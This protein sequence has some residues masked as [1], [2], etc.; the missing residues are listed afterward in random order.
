MHKIWFFWKCLVWK[1]LKNLKSNV[2]C[3][4][5]LIMI[6]KLWFYGKSIEISE[7]HNVYTVFEL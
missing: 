4:Y 5:F 6:L 1:S 3:C 7:E 2:E